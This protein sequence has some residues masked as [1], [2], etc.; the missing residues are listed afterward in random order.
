MKI[1]LYK[2]NLIITA[3][4]VKIE[5]DV[6]YNVYAKKEDGKTDFSKILVRDEVRDEYLDMMSS[7]LEDLI[8]WRKQEYDTSNLIMYLFEKLPIQK[9]KELQQ[10]ISKTYQFEEE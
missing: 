9:Q 7:V 3:D 6:F 5:E 4:N 10:Q 2:G 8:Y 1:E